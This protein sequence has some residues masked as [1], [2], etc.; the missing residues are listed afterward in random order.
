MTKRIEES[1]TPAK[2][3]KRR[4]RRPVLS[5]KAT[6]ARVESKLQQETPTVMYLELPAP[7][8]SPKKVVE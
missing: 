3:I 2:E 6:E 8:T 7:K 4:V 1:E 5:I